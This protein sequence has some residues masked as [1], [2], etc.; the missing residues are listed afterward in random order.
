MAKRK[1]KSSPYK[2]VNRIEV[3]IWD[4]YVGAV[5]LDSSSGFYVFAYNPEFGRSGISL[6]PIHMLRFSDQEDHRH[7]AKRPP[8]RSKPNTVSDQE[9]HPKGPGY[10]GV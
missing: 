7:G 6:S 3:Y 9:D 10:G 4:R 1:K 5:A 2:P 8:S